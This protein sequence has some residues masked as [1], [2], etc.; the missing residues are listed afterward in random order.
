MTALCVQSEDRL[1]RRLAMP[2]APC[3]QASDAEAEERERGGFGDAREGP[4][5]DEGIHVRK[6]LRSGA[7]SSGIDDVPEPET[8]SPLKPVS[9][10]AG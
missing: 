8:R 5:P 6:E 2:P 9:R 3:A 10:A 1:L 7:N 4:D